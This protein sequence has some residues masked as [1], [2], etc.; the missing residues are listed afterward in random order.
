MTKEVLQADYDENYYEGH[1]CGVAYNR[2]E[3]H[4]SRFFGNVADHIVKGLNAR[5]VFDAGCA[6]GFLVEELR[7]RHVEAFG[8]DFSEY[9]IEKVPETLKPFCEVGSIVD[10]I[11]GTYDLVTCIEVIEH[12]TEMDGRLAIANLCTVAP[13]ILFSSS[14]DAFDEPTHINVQ[15]PLYWL[16]IFREHGFGPRTAHDPSYLCSWAMLLERRD[17]MATDEELEAY[18][19]IVQMRMDHLKQLQEQHRHLGDV[20]ADY[21]R[22]LDALRNEHDAHVAG[23]TL[24][25][26]T[27][28]ETHRVAMEIEKSQLE[29]RIAKL[30]L[31][32]ETEVETRRVAME[33]KKG[34]LESRIAT[35]M[36]QH[37]TEA[38]AYR[39]TVDIEKAEK[40]AIILELNGRISATLS[41]VNAM[42]ASTSWGITAPYRKVGHQVLRARYVAKTIPKLAKRRGGYLKFL[43]SAAQVISRSGLRGAVSSW[44][45]AN[46][47]QTEETARNKDES[48]VTAYASWLET[49]AQLTDDHRMQIRFD[50]EAFQTRP[51]ISIVMPVYNPDLQWLD[52]AIKSVTSQLYPHWELCIADDCSTKKGVRQFLER[53]AA[54]DP[55]IK[56]VLRKVNGH[57]S[58][59]SNSAIGLATGKWMAL[60]DQDDLLSEDALYYIAKTINKFPDCALIYSDEDKIEDGLR[61]DPYFKPDWNPDL[62]RS[63][64][65]I[66][67]LGVYR[68]ER[69]RAIGGFRKGYEGAQDHDLVLR[70]TEG[71]KTSEIKHVTRVLYHWRSHAESTA[72][73][74]GNKSY[75]SFAG[76]RALVDHLERLGLAGDIEILPTGMYRVKYEIPDFAPKV[77]LIIPTRNGF[78]LISQCIDSILEK[79]TYPNY[80]IMVV[81]NNSDDQ[82]T[83]DYLKSLQG[84]DRVKIIHDHHPFNYSAINN[85]AVELA[86]GEYIGLINNDIEVISPNWL[87][88]M[89]GIAIQREVGVVGARLWYPN[90]TLQHGGVIL[91]IHGVAGHAHK[92]MPKGAHG[93]FGRGEVIQTMS[94]VTAACIVVRKSTFE[95]VR[96]LDADNL[97]IAF[98]DVD[99]CLKVREAGF[100]NV[101]TPYAELYHHESASR[102]YEDTPEKMDRFR[103]EVHFMME[104]WKDHLPFD[105]AYNPNLTLISD[106]F[107][108]AWPPRNYG[109]PT[110]AS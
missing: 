64:N 91:G 99:F 94:A 74:G 62:L 21:E 80:D 38:E 87:D 92:M 23:M 17:T 22:R 110:L 27:E 10:V 58:E 11:E 57:I 102:G 78:E 14:P 65:M 49:Y 106:D 48:I 47:L 59:A 8:R 84:N 103:S 25:H 71:L 79:T 15:P 51:V 44:R 30:M 16:R 93:Y 5:K 75:A 100:R 42:R 54:A 13:L 77:N 7:R 53:Q 76:Q 83:L 63:Q 104:K 66:S 86:D 89:M 107:S 52:E 33:I 69:V 98:N 60:L 41:A 45:L 3:T 37:E 61:R 35:L 90:D 73:S 72:Q 105:P 12:M 50:I 81:D 32:H 28:V 29:S 6:I 88:E 9:A 108:L 82:R 95:M 67:H 34:Q 24:Q 36:L 43:T 46:M 40:D 70:F 19:S 85:R 31:Q 97:K 26:E 1:F 55:R 96:G 68:L 18:A 101:W 109:D 56:I 2:S 20:R 4:W 39:A